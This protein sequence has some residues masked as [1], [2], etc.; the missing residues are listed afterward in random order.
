MAAAIGT[1]TSVLMPRSAWTLFGSDEYLIFP[2][3]TPIICE[4][5]Q[6]LKDRI[7]D[8]VEHTITALGLDRNAD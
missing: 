1:P 2:K 5:G 7:P 4:Y 3:M 8:L 6:P